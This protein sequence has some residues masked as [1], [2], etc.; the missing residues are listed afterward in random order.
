MLVLQAECIV[1]QVFAPPATGNHHH[2]DGNSN[3]DMMPVFNT[4]FA[5]RANQPHPHPLQRWLI[6]RLCLTQWL[7]LF[8]IFFFCSK[9]LFFPVGSLKLLR[10]YA[11]TC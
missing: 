8:C 3:W 7:E 5:G 4:N 9:I 2:A 1:Q 6:R 11:R 10:D